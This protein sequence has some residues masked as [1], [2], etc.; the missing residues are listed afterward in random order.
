M[1]KNR[2][3]IVFTIPIGLVAFVII[4]SLT[5][6]DFD[7]NRSMTVC[8]DNNWGWYEESKRCK[9]M[10][11]S[12]CQSL[13]GIHEACVP[14]SSFVEGMEISTMDCNQVCWLP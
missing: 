11:Q 14:T 4:I 7:E 5:A 2:N 1:F 10:T 9:G 12:I 6:I 3:P 8:V 13:N